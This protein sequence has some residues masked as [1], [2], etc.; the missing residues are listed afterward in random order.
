MS[1]DAWVATMQRDDP[2]GYHDTSVI[3]CPAMMKAGRYNIYGP[4]R[5]RRSV[6]QLIQLLNIQEVAKWAVSAK[7]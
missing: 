5:C 1:T 7:Q 3:R 4:V 2:T 6:R